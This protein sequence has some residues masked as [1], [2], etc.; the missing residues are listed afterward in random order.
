MSAYFL[1]I[2]D[3]REEGSR[4]INVVFLEKK[5]ATLKIKDFSN[6]NSCNRHH[7]YLTLILIVTIFK[8]NLLLTL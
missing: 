2:T 7:Y 1:Y 4:Y 5:N 3:Q 6:D 8:K